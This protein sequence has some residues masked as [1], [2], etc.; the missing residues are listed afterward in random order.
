[1][2]PDKF[3]IQRSATV[4]AGPEKIFP[5]INNFHKWASWSPWEKLDPGMKRTFDGSPSGKGAVYEWSGKGKAGAGRMEIVESDQPGKVAIKLDFIKPFEGH[6][7]A[8]FHLQPKGGSTEVTWAM[9]SPV[10]FMMKVMH[11]FMNMDKMV[12]KDFE[13]GLANLK[14]LAERG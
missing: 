1:M 2:K 10:N 3:L 14:T 13:S 12:G 7:M 5:H 11:V 8:E 6:S 4:T 9:H